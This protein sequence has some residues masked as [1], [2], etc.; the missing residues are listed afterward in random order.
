MT[1]STLR[2]GFD[3]VP[4]DPF[5]VQVREAAQQ[6]AEELGI[7][8]VPIAAPT[9]S[10]TDDTHLSFLEDLKVHELGALITQMLP[11]ALLRAVLNGGLPVICA[12]DTALH[13]PLLVS[14]HGLEQAAIMVAEFAVSRLNG[15]GRILIAGA[16]GDTAQTARV[17]VKGFYA[18][19]AAYPQVHARH[20][21][22]S[23]NYDEA[24]AELR[25]GADE[26]L[27]DFPDGHIDAIIGLSDPLAL[28][29][30]DA[31]RELGVVDHRTLVIGING[32][33]LAIAAI[34]AK[35][36]HATVETSPQALGFKL[37]EFGQRAALR[38]PLPEHIPYNL[39]LVTAENVATV[40]ARKLLAIADLPSRLVNLNRRSEQ[41]RLVQLEA[42]L[43]LNQ[44]V[45]SI[46]DQ[47]ELLDTMA[48][49][50]AT[51][52]DYDRVHFYL[53]SNQERSLV[54][55]N[56]T[57]STADD[58]LISLASSGALGKALLNNQTVYIPDTLNSKR[59]APDP[60][61]PDIQARVVLPVRVGGRI[62]GVLDLHS[63]HPAL[64]NQAELDALQTLADEFGTAMRNA[65]LYTQAVQA[66]A[67]AVQAALVRVRQLTGVGHQMQTI[68]SVILSYCESVTAT[69]YRHAHAVPA[70]LLED[71]RH[72]E[73]NSADLH[74]LINSLLELTQAETGI[75]QLNLEP[76]NTNEFL[77]DVFDAAEQTFAVQGSVRWR[78]Q[79][80]AQLPI[81]VADPVRL[82][83]I[84]L[85]LLANAA[86]FTERGQVV[87][88]AMAADGALQI[89]VEDTGCGIAP[90]MLERIRQNLVLG[91]GATIDPAAPSY[92]HGWGLA[93][94]SQL[95]ERHE[96]EFQI[97]SEVGQGTTCRIRLPMKNT[98][99]RLGREPGIH[100]EAGV[101]AV[102]SERQLTT[103]V[104]KTREF[105]NNNFATPF[106]REQIAAALGVSPTYVSRVFHRQTGM[107][108]WDYVNGF[109]IA[110]ACDLLQHSDMPVTEVAFAVGFN[111][112]A[113]FSRVFRREIGKSPA[114]YRHSMFT[115]SYS[116]RG[117]S[118]RSA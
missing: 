108:L 72:I 100:P 110:R 44:R 28:A 92:E 51:H 61:W 27:P 39:E 97:E 112:P 111:D 94:V 2:V 36:M 107:A 26:W 5:W 84:L 7:S 91:A 15:A 106:T 85:N 24:A 40:A 105:V 41:Q 17:R 74:L 79:I 83:T 23:W 54:L 103:L 57:P 52:Y 31:G 82:R 50:I 104:E 55:A 16:Q 18:V 67:E 64:R 53:W 33:P 42:S 34:E 10:S 80:L 93:I 87:L 58:A 38:E 99:R 101:L 6:R 75:R 113:Y 11:D 116:L 45:G 32:D 1:R 12:E 21:A 102:Q 115:M 76:I 56:R 86:K 14:V 25:E 78:L 20:F 89:W 81:L 19:F 3:L 70:K 90:E 29:A 65:Q 4:G 35:T 62:L 96:G 48:E 77:K 109:R 9:R 46:L 60:R 68:L 13:H 59:Y 8:L 66:K 88:G 69:A 98:H 47:Q 95:V 30:R 22:T 118:P 114:T 117:S 73:S 49:I 63:R 43:A 71:V 37:A